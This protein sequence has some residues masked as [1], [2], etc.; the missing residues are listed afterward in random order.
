[1]DDKDNFLD[2]L[3]NLIGFVSV[4]A[5]TVHIINSIKKNTDTKIISEDGYSTIQN[6]EKAKQLREVIHSYH[7]NGSWDAKE[8]QS[9]IQKD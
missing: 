9:I 4:V 6:P 2:G 5:L 1:M 8:I 7:K 3:I